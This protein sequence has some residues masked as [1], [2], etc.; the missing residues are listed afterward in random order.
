LPVDA[1]NNNPFLYS[2][3]GEG[4]VL[5]SAGENGID[6][7]GSNQSQ[8]VHRGESI[9]ELDEAE[10]ERRR[11]QIAAQSDDLSTRQPTSPFKLPK[12]AADLTSQ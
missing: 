7:G 11:L 4:F 3:E 9:H 12:S 5:Y 1:I 2:R 6:D 10:A 8:E